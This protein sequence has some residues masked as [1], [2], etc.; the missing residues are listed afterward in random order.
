MA[1]KTLFTPIND[2]PVQWEKI[3]NR[4]LSR[5]LYE[6]AIE[7]VIAVWLGVCRVPECHKLPPTAR[8]RAANVWGA[9][10]IN[11][12]SPDLLLANM[13]AGVNSGSCCVCSVSCA[14]SLRTTSEHYLSCH[15]FGAC[16]HISGA[17]HGLFES[18]TKKL[19]ALTIA[20]D[21]INWVTDSMTRLHLSDRSLQVVS[22]SRH[23]SRFKPFLCFTIT[24]KS[25]QLQDL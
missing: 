1:Q 5:T 18:L 14:L 19:Y 8:A 15:G 13:G 23:S 24:E 11:N 3:E 4:V 12:I 10:Q 16:N 17:N 2:R 21:S 6:T 9:Q 20:I 22:R 25:M 7:R